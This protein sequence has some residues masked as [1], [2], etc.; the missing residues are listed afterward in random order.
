MSNKHKEI[1]HSNIQTIREKLGFT[2]K[3]MGEKLNVSEKTIRNYEYFETNFPL[4]KAMY[5]S[6]EYGYSL[7]W[8]YGKSADKETDP[9]F[10][11][12][13]RISKFIVDIR[14]YISRSNGTIHFTIPDYYLK[15]IKRRNKLSSSNLSDK[16]KQREIAKLDA[17]YKEKNATSL[18]YHFSFPEANF[19]PFLHIDKDFVP[20]VES[21]SGSD[22]RQP[23]D[24]QKQEMQSFFDVLLREEDE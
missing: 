7:D 11:G 1:I 14:D 8:I 13:K 21:V 23:T 17:S 10:N 6:R 3:E 5:L 15:Y 9:A 18:Y 12:G 16:E 24:E 4:D 2:Q 22:D 19:M 20:Y